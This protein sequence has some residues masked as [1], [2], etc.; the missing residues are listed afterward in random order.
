M[1]RR[2]HSFFS[3]IAPALLSVSAAIAQPGAAPK[4]ATPPAGLPAKAPEG[5]GVA[6]NRPITAVNPV[7][8]ELSK[9]AIA[10]YQAENFE[11][12]LSLFREAYRIDR[13]PRWLYNIGV[14]YDRMG[15]SDDAAFFYRAGLFGK[16]VL[17]Q[18]VKIVEERLGALQE[19]CK[20]KERHKLV[21]DRH[22]RAQRYTQQKLCALAEDI[23]TG[24]I[25]PAERQ[26]IEACKA[27]VA[28][29][30]A[31]AGVK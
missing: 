21:T 7:T 2:A 23:L 30:Q 22:D 4:A 29:M 10:A 13:N 16:G 3:V 31:A 18:D 20:F 25:T 8:N 24:I 27:E 15:N 19:D 26:N 6:A 28:K 17:Q 11:E 1:I 14:V 12:S 9:R 5:A